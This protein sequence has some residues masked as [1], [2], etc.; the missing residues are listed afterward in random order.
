MG[1]C[2]QEGQTGE[3][4]VDLVCEHEGDRQVHTD[5][6]LLICVQLLT[7]HLL[8]VKLLLILIFQ[9]AFSKQPVSLDLLQVFLLPELICT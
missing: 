2:R 1:V 4:L 6:H 3:K 5:L 9:H 8:P 7:P